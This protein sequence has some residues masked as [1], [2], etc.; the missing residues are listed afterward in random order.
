MKTP[1]CRARRSPTR[2]FRNFTRRIPCTTSGR[3]D[4]HQTNAARINMDATADS[5]S[6]PFKRS[7]SARS[8]FEN[9]LGVTEELPGA[10]GQS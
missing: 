4:H 5:T 3:C 9:P 2:R 7:L 1:I 10:S 8:R 6:D